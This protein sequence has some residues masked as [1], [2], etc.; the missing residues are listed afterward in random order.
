MVFYALVLL[1]LKILLEWFVDDKG[2]KRIPRHLQPWYRDDATIT[3]YF[4]TINT[5][6]SELLGKGPPLEYH[7]K[8][9]KEWPI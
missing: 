6:F 1:P 5:W 4:A 9:K 3:A 2:R 8:P 7:P